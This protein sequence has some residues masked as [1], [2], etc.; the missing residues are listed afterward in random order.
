MIRAQGFDG[1]KVAVFGL[2]VSGRAA[3]ASLMAGGADVFAWDDSEAARDQAR[4]EGIEL[5][6]LVKADWREFAFLVL[7]P[8]V[9]LTHPEPHWTVKRARDAGVEIIGDTEIFMRALMAGNLAHN[10]IAITGTNGKSTTTALIGH[11]L[12]EAGLE[13]EIGGNIGTPVLALRPPAE[14]LFY[15]VEFSSY[16]IDLTPS[17]KPG[18]AILLNITPDHLDRHGSLEHY[19][20]VKARIFAGQGAG[21]VAVV[22][23]DDAPSRKIA[24]GIAP[25]ANR[26]EISVLRET[27]GLY[28][29]DGSLFDGRD[30]PPSKLG[31]FDGMAGLRGV[32]NWQNAAAAYAVASARFGLTAETVF[33]AFNS[34]PGLVH[35]MEQ[36]GEINGVA[37]VN[38]S[39][40]TNAEAAARALDSFDEIYWIAGGQAKEGGIDSLAEYFPKI[41]KAYLI[42]EA[43]DAFADLLTPHM[44]VEKCGT[45]ERAAAAAF[46]DVTANNA[47]GE[48]GERAILFSPA[49][50]SFDQYRNFEK[51]G[52]AFKAA[53]E[54]LLKRGAGS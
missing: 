26:I 47:R 34:F 14:D 43:Q 23:V 33:A 49:C 36:I 38:D 18:V 22:G 27:D 20:A 32:H 50:A 8:G 28:A 2:G 25:V 51:R 54:N 29:R 35:R 31:S 48:A 11:V 37:I 30:A 13:V 9:P 44:A 5:S 15:V 3:A 45:V 16:Q 4:A 40:A 19:A 21:D 52:E 24:S 12:G 39:K 17:L 42:G 6:D 53:V 41:V 10:L 1:L 46:R 7:A